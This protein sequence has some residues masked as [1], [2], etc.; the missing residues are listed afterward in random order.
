MSAVGTPVLTKTLDL[1]NARVEF[2]N[3]AVANLTSS[4]V[5]Q[6]TQRKFRVFQANQ[7]VSIDFQH[8]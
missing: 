3:G 2:K 4:R 7:Y 1:A 6:T 5:S 8:R